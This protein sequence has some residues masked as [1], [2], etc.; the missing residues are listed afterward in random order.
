LLASLKE[1]ADLTVGKVA[2]IPH[3]VTTRMLAAIAR[4]EGKS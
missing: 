1:I 4:A 2:T 3:E